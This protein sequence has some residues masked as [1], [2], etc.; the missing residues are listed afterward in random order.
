MI[1]TLRLDFYT[2]SLFGIVSTVAGIFMMKSWG[3]IADRLGNKPV[4]LVC[5]WV[6]AIVPVFWL[7]A[8]EGAY[9]IPL[10]V[11]HAIGGGFTA[12]IAL[13]QTNMVVELAPE[14]RR[15]VYLSVFAATTGI[16]GAFGPIVGGAFAESTRGLRFDVVGIEVTN[17]HLQFLIAAVLQAGLVLYL[18]RVEE[19]GAAK[20]VT[21]IMQLRN[22]LDPL[23]GIGSAMDFLEV[24]GRRATGA[25]L[26]RV[27]WVLDWMI[28]HVR[29][30]QERLNAPRA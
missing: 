28:G 16:V 5:G 8:R 23:T 25:V 20:P 12:G 22:D 18:D 15:S 13:S 21:V 1:E 9:G 14:R 19:V 2:I 10:A 24:E 4:M 7:L 17:L 29:R 3:P 26:R 30:A 27:E 6:I 11:A